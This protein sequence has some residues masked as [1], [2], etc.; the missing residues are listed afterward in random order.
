M[1]WIVSAEAELEADIARLDRMTPD[2]LAAE[3]GW[4]ERYAAEQGLLDELDARY[5]AELEKRAHH[6]YA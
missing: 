4:C 3:T 1:T 5:R 2:E 6:I